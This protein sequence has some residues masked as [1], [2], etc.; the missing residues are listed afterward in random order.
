MSYPVADVRA[1]C[2]QVVAAVVVVEAGLLVQVVQTV[3][4]Q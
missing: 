1:P 2:L 3:T 4:Q